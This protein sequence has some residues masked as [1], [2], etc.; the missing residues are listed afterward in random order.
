MPVHGGGE[1]SPLVFRACAAEE[2][3]VANVDDP[4]L[5][6]IDLSWIT[7]EGLTVQDSLGW[8]R[9]ENAT[10]VV[11]RDNV[12]LRATATG[13]TGGVKLVDSSYCRLEGNRFE[14]GNDNVVV[15][16]SDYNVVAGNTF[17]RGRHSLFSGPRWAPS[18]CRMPRRRI[19][20][21]RRVAG[22]GG[23]CTRCRRSRPGRS[24]RRSG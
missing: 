15:Q 6:V 19:L 16:H 9:L 11:L 22:A 14:D 1:A 7:I 5:R 3:I 24:R 17:V 23:A 4:A 10:H 8:A 18:S 13:T 20:G 21:G 2:P 12:F